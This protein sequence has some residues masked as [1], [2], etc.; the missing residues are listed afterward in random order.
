MKFN[1]YHHANKGAQ[2]ILLE[3][4]RKIK[5]NETNF[6]IDKFNNIIYENCKSCVKTFTSKWL[7]TRHVEQVHEKRKKY[8]CD[9]CSENFKSKF[10]LTKHT[11]NI[12][13]DITG[14]KICEIKEL[15][16]GKEKCTF[17]DKGYKN[18]YF[19]TKHIE[20]AHEQNKHNNCKNCG[21][22]FKSK[23]LLKKHIEKMYSKIDQVY[24]EEISPET[25]DSQKF[26]TQ[27]VEDQLMNTEDQSTNTEDQLMHTEDQ[28]MNTKDQLMNI[29][30]QLM[31]TDDK[32]LNI[33]K[34]R[35]RPDEGKDKFL[36][37][38]FC[39]LLLFKSKYSKV[40]HTIDECQKN[41]REKNDL[42]TADSQILPI[43]PVEDT[44]NYKKPD[45][46]RDK[47]LTCKTCGLLLF[48]S[49]YSRTDHTIDICQKNI[50]YKN[51][52]RRLLLNQE[53]NS[54]FLSRTQQD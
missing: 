52:L 13:E 42:R 29:K 47:F 38:K 49:K 12:K 30:D 18:K 2:G 16:F 50:K 11:K 48:E 35:N 45:E 37:C 31:N 10:L 54:N 43:K 33:E 7:L 36:T 21:E 26:S 34:V 1:N 25:G 44:E 51:D 40:D 15:P 20:E 9:N 19:L 6:I 8:I 22:K 28:L 32:L 23:F 39:G 3:S 17:C 14:T 24:I 41:I 27:P 46:G 5:I 53:E 4:Q